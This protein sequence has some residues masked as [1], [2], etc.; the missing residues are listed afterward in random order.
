MKQMSC[1]HEKAVIRTL[2]SGEWTPELRLHLVD[3][4]D[5]SEA[6]QLAEALREGARRAEIHCNPPDAHWVLQRSRRMAREIA[7][8]RVDWLLKAMRTLAAVYV[9]AAAVWLLRGYAE[10]Q[11]R[12]VASALHGAAAGFALMGATVA[13]VCVVAG[14]FPILRQ[15]AVSAGLYPT[16]G[17]NR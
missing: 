17:K 8:R 6:L 5:C 11:F 16:K 1:E 7:M 4:Q 10:L 14:L 12:G 15:S 3:C 2:H 13:A 9:I